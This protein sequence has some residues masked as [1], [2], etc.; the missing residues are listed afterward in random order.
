MVGWHCDKESRENSP[1]KTHDKVPI[2][3]HHALFHPYLANRHVGDKSNLV[4]IYWATLDCKT[5]NIFTSGGGGD[6][7]S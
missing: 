7:V 2:S 5:L 4:S 1:S 3:D 6:A